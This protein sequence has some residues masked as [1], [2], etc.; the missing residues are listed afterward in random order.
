M[1]IRKRPSKKTK[2]GYVYQVYFN[3]VDS[4]GIKSKY[5]KSG[6]V[7]KKEAV[8]HEAF[9]KEKLK[10]NRGVYNESITFNELFEE[11]MEIEGFNKYAK[12]TSQYYMNAYK[13]YIKEGI[14]NRAISSLKYKDLQKFFNNP[15][16]TY[17]NLFNLRKVFGVTYTYAIKNGYVYDNPIR[18]ISLTKK[19]E[20]DD[21]QEIITEEQL[22]QIVENV[23]IMDKNC[24][25]PDY[26]Q[27][28]YYSYAIAIYIGWYTGLRI[29][30]VFGLQKS[31][32]D[33]EKNTI[34]I[35]KRLEYHG[36]K[37]EDLNTTNKMKTK[38]SKAIIPL[39]LP[40]KEILIGWFA[41]NPYE[42]VICDINGDYIHP[43]AITARIANVS[44]RLDIPFHFHALRHNFTTNLINNGVKPNIVKELVRHGDIAT[45]LG[46]YTH[47]NND[48]LSKTIEEIYGKEDK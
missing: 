25:D 32:I 5:Y 48:D 33:F 35:N 36:V 27:F 30:E 24:P 13:N 47:V 31:D 6:F 14:G 23:I 4:N 20:K 29:S 37:K 10:R 21:R 18:M 2:S 26:T 15:N 43:S 39:A 7:L 38:A 17:A 42:K 1:S 16:I 9:M 28:N 3:Y 40:L 8:E 41:F 44:K 11:Y 19:K 12:A 46:I 45:T 34:N 22:K